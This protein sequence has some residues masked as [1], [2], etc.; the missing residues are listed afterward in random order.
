M[1]QF[2]KSPTD[3]RVKGK[4]ATLFILLPALKKYIPYAQFW[5]C[6]LNGTKWMS[7]QLI[8]YVK[9]IF[10]IIFFPENFDQV[11]HQNVSVWYHVLMQWKWK[12]NIFWYLENIWLPLLASKS[13]KFLIKRTHP[14][15]DF[16]Y[17]TLI[18]FLSIDYRCW[19]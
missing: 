1:V 7:P 11:N 14:I 17:M 9:I 19:L 16:L 6:S 5:K 12:Q 15:S 4:W 13:L 3:I 8:S 2:C 18:F 10:K